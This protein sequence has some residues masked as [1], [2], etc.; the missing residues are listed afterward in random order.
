MKCGT[1]VWKRNPLSGQPYRATIRCNQWKKCTICFEIHMVAWKTRLL[2]LIAQNEGKIYLKILN[3]DEDT[4]LTIRRIRNHKE[5]FYKF[6]PDAN[7][8]FHTDEVEGGAKMTS[9]EVNGLDFA[10]L[11]STKNYSRISTNIHLPKPEGEVVA[12]EAVSTNAPL[13]D[14]VDAWNEALKQSVKPTTLKET[15]VQLAI[16]T[17]LFK[18]IIEAKGYI[19]TLAIIVRQRI[20]IT[21]VAWI[22]QIKMP[23]QGRKRP[24]NPY[25]G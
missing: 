4:R 6:C 13:K 22:E 15:L 19:V 5:K 24:L 12:T 8:V 14:E 3:S 20:K 16:T 7:Y 1:K 10:T 9:G 25:F 21:K 23:Y 2:E 18:K 11:T 17:N